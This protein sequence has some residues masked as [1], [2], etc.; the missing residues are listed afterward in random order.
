MASAEPA[1]SA[2]APA[3]GIRGLVL[4][5]VVWKGT[6]QVFLQLARAAVAIALARLLAPH[7][8]GLAAMVLV[9][10]SL[11]LVFSDLALGAALVQ[12]PI[13]TEAERATVFWTSIAAGMGFTLLG[14]AVAEPVARFYHEPAVRGLVTV[15]SLGFGIAA[16][17]TLPS[18]LLTRA[19]DFRALEVR[20][21]V[22]TLAGAI[23]GIG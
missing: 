10:S 5:G 6:S 13:V 17:G 16:L 4:R 19:M 3:D 9:F 21:M 8:F 1:L 18:A 14:V 11:V 12:R 15:L 20:S 2:A 22:A 7:D 23:V